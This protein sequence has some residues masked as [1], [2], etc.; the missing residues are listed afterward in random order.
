MDKEKLIPPRVWHR[1]VYCDY[2]GKYYNMIALYYGS[3]KALL[4]DGTLDMEVSVSDMELEYPSYRVDRTGKMI[5][6]GDILS[7]KDHVFPIFRDPSCGF[8][9]KFGTWSFYWNHSVGSIIVGNIRENKLMLEAILASNPDIKTYMDK[10]KE[11][12]AMLG[13]DISIYA[14]IV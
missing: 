9:F 3:K 7:V 1:S 14:G 5:Y 13:T 4:S 8:R 12:T 2:V 10:A 11:A 6:E